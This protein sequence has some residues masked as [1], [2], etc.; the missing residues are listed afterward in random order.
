MAK[1]DGGKMRTKT[2]LFK[3]PL[4]GKSVPELV[5][6]LQGKGIATKFEVREGWKGN[7]P[8]PL[9]LSLSMAP[10]RTP[11][12]PEDW[13]A[14]KERLERDLTESMVANMRA[15]SAPPQPADRIDLI[16][17]A[18]SEVF[19]ALDAAEELIDRLS[20]N[21]DVKGVTG[22]SAQPVSK[23]LSHYL[24]DLPPKL[25]HISSRLRAMRTRAAES[26]I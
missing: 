13:P 19:E 26:L 17:S 24:T 16:E 10:G 4:E 8:V 15:P 23:C 18:F 5:S 20:G 3:K 1:K 21:S 14:K 11:T 22:S 9:T 25:L 12:A 6:A 7:G 2:I